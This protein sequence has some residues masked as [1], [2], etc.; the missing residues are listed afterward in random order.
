MYVVATEGGQTT[1]KNAESAL[2]TAESKG[3]T[4]NK[5]GLA[6]PLFSSVRSRPAPEQPHL[7]AA[8]PSSRPTLF[9]LVAMHSW[10]RPMFFVGLQ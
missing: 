6:K 1:D 3:F 2:C 8:K 7:H 9:A 5:T 4:R 10:I